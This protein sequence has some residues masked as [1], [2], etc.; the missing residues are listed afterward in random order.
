M[1][2]SQWATPWASPPM[3]RRVCKDR[4]AGSQWS[5]R[6]SLLA[7]RGNTSVV[8][9]LGGSS[10]RGGSSTMYGLYI[11]RPH[12]AERSKGQ[13]EGRLHQQDG[14]TFK[15]E[16]KKTAWKGTAGYIHLLCS[17]RYSR[18]QRL[19]I[20]RRKVLGSAIQ[21]S[22]CRW[23]RTVQNMYIQDGSSSVDSWEDGRWRMHSLV[24]S[25]P[26]EA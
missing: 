20:L 10:W 8:E 13:A 14:R 3:M 5:L 15:W 7:G 21:W 17:Q 19:R 16:K 9:A 2:K 1:G 18:C 4:D 23:H 25:N 24:G 12:R 6:R 22:L 11:T 26:V